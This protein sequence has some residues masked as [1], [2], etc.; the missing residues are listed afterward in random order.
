MNITIKLLFGKF[1]CWF[2]HKKFSKSAILTGIAVLIGV[3]SSIGIWHSRIANPQS[4]RTTVYMLEENFGV[5]LNLDRI[6][7][8]MDKL[9]NAAIE[10]LNE[11]TCKNTISLFQKKIDMI[12]FDCTTICFESFAEDELNKTVTVRTGNS[13]S[14]R[15]YWPYW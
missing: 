11:I 4:K 7:R 8:M 3:T 5:P 12:F 14:Q 1:I 9:D 2:N 13:I 15:Y 10:R 6:Y